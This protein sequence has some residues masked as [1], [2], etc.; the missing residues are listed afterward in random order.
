MSRL[1]KIR[2]A[3]FRPDETLCTLL[4]KRLPDGEMPCATGFALARELG[5]TTQELGHY[6]DHLNLRLVRCQIGL[7]GQGKGKAKLIHTLDRVDRALREAVDAASGDGVITCEQVFEI[8]RT[9]KLSQVAVGSAC[10][11]L[12]IKI[13]QCRF[14]AF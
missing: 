6:A 11:T 1:T 13:R 3:D 9:L 14:G 5:I 10:E 4:T 8:A 7:F 12:G 2:P